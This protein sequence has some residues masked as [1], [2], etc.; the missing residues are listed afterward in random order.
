ME[1]TSE[2][3]V[4]H[5]D[6]LRADGT[7]YDAREAAYLQQPKYNG[8]TLGD[9]MARATRVVQSSSSYHYYVDG[10]GGAALVLLGLSSAGGRGGGGFRCGGGGGGGGRVRLK[11]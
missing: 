7:P 4:W 9:H 5:H 6:V 11:K 3:A 2:P 8:I 10:V 1:F